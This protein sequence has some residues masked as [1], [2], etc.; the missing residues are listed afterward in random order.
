M[1]ADRD[2]SPLQEDTYFSDLKNYNHRIQEKKWESPLQI[3]N[4]HSWDKLQS[5]HYFHFYIKLDISLST[6]VYVKVCRHKNIKYMT[7]FCPDQKWI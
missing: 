6:H 1:D 5:Q 3:I 2:I 4:C 7:M